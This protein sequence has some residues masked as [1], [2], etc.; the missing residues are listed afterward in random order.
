MGAQPWHKHY[1]TDFV[2]GVLGLGAAEIGAYIVILDLIYD[3]GGPIPNN[4]RWIG[5]I[6]GEHTKRTGALISH[7]ITAGK[8]VS[9]DGTL[10][11]NRAEIELESARNR[12]EIAAKSGKKGGIVRG[13]NLK[14]Q[15]LN[16]SKPSNF[17]S[18]HARVPEATR[19]ENPLN[20][21]FFSV[22]C[23]EGGSSPNGASS[24]TPEEFERRRQKVELATR[25]FSGGD[26]FTKATGGV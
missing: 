19:E 9:V 22:A 3:R 7:L 24:D 12:A 5:S 4:S 26:M 13:R 8:L 6:L 23:P 21:V 18:T 15:T 11:N 20:R 14:N 10:D 17:A 2:H 25:K 1:H 16:S